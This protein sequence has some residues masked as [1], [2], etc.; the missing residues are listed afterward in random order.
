MQQAR[1]HERARRLHDGHD[2]S[3]NDAGMSG[4]AGRRRNAFR[5]ARTRPGVLERLE[6]RDISGHGSGSGSV[7]GQESGSEWSDRVDGYS[8]KLRGDWM[9][10]RARKRRRGGGDDDDA[11]EFRDDGDE[12]GGGGGG[13]GG[14]DASALTAREQ[15]PRD[16]GR[17]GRR[18]NDWLRTIRMNDG[19]ESVLPDEYSSRDQRN[20]DVKKQSTSGDGYA[21]DESIM[22]VDYSALDADAPIPTT[23][24]SPLS[25][26][27]SRHTTPQALK[28]ENTSLDK[29]RQW[30]MTEEL[31]FGSL[32]TSTPAVP[33][34]EQKKNTA[35]D[36]I[37]RREIENVKEMAVARSQLN[38]IKEQLPEEERS[39]RP[40]QI[41]RSKQQQQQQQLRTN[42]HGSNKEEE[43]QVDDQEKDISKSH[44]RA[45]NA[46][47][48]STHGQG[49]SSKKESLDSTSPVMVYKY[50][51][52]YSEVDR[53]TQAKAQLK[54]HS[55]QLHHRHD[56]HDLLRRLAR[57]TS[58]SPSP[59]ASSSMTSKEGQRRGKRINNNI[60]DPLLP[61]KNGIEHDN[62]GAPTDKNIKK[63]SPLG[64]ASTAVAS[65]FKSALS[66]PVRDMPDYNEQDRDTRRGDPKRDN[67]KSPK[68]NANNQII[69][70][71]T[72][73]VTGAWIDTPAPYRKAYLPTPTPDPD[74]ADDA[75]QHSKEDD[76]N[77]ANPDV[78]DRKYPRS[79]LAAILEEA[80]GAKSSISNALI[81]RGTA[82][83]GV[84]ENEI[85][86]EI[87]HLGDS[88][89][90][91][92][93]DLISPLDDPYSGDITQL[94]EDTMRSLQLPTEPPKTRAEKQ[95]YQELVTLKEMNSR[96]K[97]ARTSI[98]DAS[99]SIR[100][101][102][103]QVETSE[104]HGVGIDNGT[105][106]SRCGCPGGINGRVIVIK[107]PWPVI[108][109]LLTTRTH[110]LTTSLSARKEGQA[111]RRLNLLGWFV[112]PLLCW[113]VSEVILRYVCGHSA[114]VLG[115]YILLVIS[116]YRPLTPNAWSGTALTR[117]RLV[118][119]TS[120]SPF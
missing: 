33:T 105:R 67:E 81:A 87:D 117:I 51:Q 13:G 16:W 113:Y 112:V 120:P 95:R 39:K 80:K 59:G 27:G 62:D 22:Q 98:R 32:I 102:E 19:V 63:K 60:Q 70:A 91:S 2:E 53:E 93:E 82:E 41:R 11:L 107:S 114:T 35:L 18:G 92:L 12:G 9:S 45:N 40:S 10:E 72:P 90:Q 99:R 88:T 47:P 25:K 5:K 49:T 65:A 37:R 100:R 52:T 73:V 30:E 8:G 79:V 23:E 76:E 69:V 56:S 48:G 111:E 96:L 57:A 3:R 104:D 6:R 64:R 44:V 108:K 58:N 101:V 118:H 36:D 46:G 55:S 115:A 61:E 14:V 85:N 43:R 110:V 68:P 77:R 4:G 38:K 83:D 71:K 109:G 54:S 84:D 20:N 106:C 75:H 31:T 1:E 42:G 17:K 89:I 28:L 15:K 34:R 78:R 97:S 66:T 29:K 26:K 116:I 86:H 24:D 50:S 21:G 103:Q 7:S 119:H 74:T 94:D